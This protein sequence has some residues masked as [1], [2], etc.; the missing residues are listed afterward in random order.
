MDQSEMSIKTIFILL[1]NPDGEEDQSENKYLFNWPIRDNP[2]GEEDQ[3][4]KD[5]DYSYL[6][7]SNP[8]FA[9]WKHL[10]SYLSSIFYFIDPILHAGALP[11][12]AQC[13]LWRVSRP[14]RTSTTCTL[15]HSSRAA[16]QLS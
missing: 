16:G 4:E 5:P 12:C 8:V 7:Q 9:R 3:S 15:S 1:Y 2:G 6:Y 10:K 14:T 13:P 11:V